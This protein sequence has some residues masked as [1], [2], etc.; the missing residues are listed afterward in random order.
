MTAAGPAE[1]VVEAAAAASAA[2]KRGL[3]ERR[4]FEV[5]HE[6]INILVLLLLSK[7]GEL[8]EDLSQ[9]YSL[10]DVLDDSGCMQLPTDE[11]F[12][13][14][15]GEMQRLLTVLYD[16]P[17]IKADRGRLA[18]LGRVL[19]KH[20]PPK[21]MS[22]ATC[23]SPSQLWR[24]QYSKAHAP[25]KRNTKP[26]PEEPENV[27]F[28]LMPDRAPSSVPR[29]E[30]SK[31]FKRWMLA[32]HP[33]K[34]GDEKQAARCSA[35]YSQA[36]AK[37][38]TVDGANPDS[39]VKV[40]ED[41]VYRQQ[42]QQAE[43]DWSRYKRAV[44]ERA[45]CSSATYLEQRL[46]KAARWHLG[47]RERQAGFLMD[48]ASAD[49]DGP[50]AVPR[51]NSN[52]QQGEGVQA[53]AARKPGSPGLAFGSRTDSH[54][55]P[56]SA[57]VRSSNTKG[58][59]SAPFSG[60]PSPNKASTREPLRPVQ[61]P[62]SDIVFMYSTADGEGL[63]SSFPNQVGRFTIRARDRLFRAVPCTPEPFHVVVRGRQTVATTVTPNP[64][65]SIGVEY[66]INVC[67]TYKIHVRGGKKGT[68]IFGSPYTLTVK[69]APVQPCQCAAEGV[70]LRKARAGEPSSFT[71]HRRDA[72]GKLIVKG[73]SRFV[74]AFSLADGEAGAD[75]Q[76]GAFA[77]AA[78]T[79]ELQDKGGTA[80][81]YFTQKV[82][83]K[84]DGT[85]VVQ[86]A[87]QRAG[88]YKLHV[89]LGVHSP[90][91]IHGSPFELHVAPA[92]IAAPS[93]E[94][95]DAMTTPLL[96]T[97]AAEA[98]V[99]RGA[100]GAI[101]V[102]AAK[103]TSNE[104]IV[105]GRP[106]FF[107]VLARDA[108]GNDV[109]LEALTTKA[110]GGEGGEGGGGGSGAGS[111]PSSPLKSPTKGGVG[112]R[113]GEGFR[114]TL[115]SS[116][117]RSLPA[118]CV[119][120]P[121]GQ[122]E[123][124]AIA[125][126][127]EAHTLNVTYGG[128][129][130]RRSPRQIAV[131]AGPLDL[132]HVTTTI[133]ACEAGRVSI[134]AVARDV[135]GNESG[136]KLLGAAIVP[137]A[138]TSIH[139]E[140]EDALGDR[141]EV[142][143]PHVPMLAKSASANERA[144]AEAEA[145]TR[146]PGS[147]AS[148][149]NMVRSVFSSDGGVEGVVVPAEWR[150]YLEKR[151]AKMA[152]ARGGPDGGYA[153]EGT[154]PSSVL[155]DDGAETASCSSSSC[156]SSSDASGEVS[157]PTS[158]KPTPH[159]KS[160]GPRA[161]Q[162]SALWFSGRGASMRSLVSK[163]GGWELPADVASE[164]RALLST[165]D[166]TKADSYTL[167][168]WAENH[169]GEGLANPER[170]GACV[171]DLATPL[172]KHA[173]VVLMQPLQL[174]PGAFSLRHSQ[175]RMP[176]Q[177]EPPRAGQN[178]G[179]G[180]LAF[181]KFGNPLRSGGTVKLSLKQLTGPPP[182][183]LP[184]QP[185]G[186]ATQHIDHNDGMHEVQ[187]T[188]Y[189]AGDHQL[190]LTATP[191]NGTDSGG[192]GGAS[193]A[194]GVA[195]AAAGT[196]NGRVL[197]LRVLP[198]DLEPSKCV[199]KPLGTD[200]SVTTPSTVPADRRRGGGVSDRKPAIQL[201]AGQWASALLQCSDSYGNPR[202]AIAA[203]ATGL[204]LEL[205]EGC[206][207]E[208]DSTMLPPSQLKSEQRLNAD[209][210]IWLR[211]APLSSGARVLSIKLKGV[212]VFGSPLRL[213]VTAGPLQLRA[214]ELM[215]DGSKLCHLNERSS[216]KLIAKDAYGNV[217][218]KG[219][220]RFFVTM[221]R[222]D[223]AGGGADGS[224]AVQHVPV[225]DDGS[226][227]Y[228]VEY[229]CTAVG[230]HSVS[231]HHGSLDGD[232]LPGSPFALRCLPGSPHLPACRFVSA[233]HGMRALM[234]ERDLASPQVFLG[235]VAACMGKLRV[236]VRLVD[237]GGLS[238]QMSS[239]R[240]VMLAMLP[241]RAPEPAAAGPSDADADGA[242]DGCDA[243]PRATK[244][245]ER[246][247]LAPT[248]KAHEAALAAWVTKTWKAQAAA[249]PAGGGGGA[250]SL[251]DGIR[252]VGGDDP[253]RLLDG[254]VLA[255]LERVPAAGG[256]PASVEEADG[257]GGST[258]IYEATVELK[259]MGHFRLAL[260]GSGGHTVTPAVAA[261]EVTP[262][263]AHALSCVVGGDAVERSCG[264]VGQPVDIWLQAHD[265]GGN[266]VVKGGDKV[267]VKVVTAPTNAPQVKAVVRDEGNGM[268]TLK[269]VPSTAGG[270]GLA[271]MVGRDHVGGSPFNF[272]IYRSPTSAANA[273]KHLG[274]PPLP[275]A[276]GLAD[277]GKGS[278]RGSA[279]DSPHSSR[280][281]A[282]PRGAPPAANTPRGNSP[283]RDSSRDGPVVQPSAL[284]PRAPSPRGGGSGSSSTG[285]GADS[286]ADSRTDSRASSPRLSRD[287]AR[288]ASPR[289]SRDAA[290]DAER[291][292]PT[293]AFAPSPAAPPPG[294][295]SK[296]PRGV[297]PLPMATGKA[298]T[299]GR[300]RDR[301][302][303]AHAPVSAR[304]APRGRSLSR[305]E[306]DWSALPE[307]LAAGLA[308]AGLAA[309]GGGPP[310]PS[311]VPP[312]RPSGHAL[313]DNPLPSPKDRDANSYVNKR[314]ESARA[315]PRR[316]T[317]P[318]AGSPRAPAPATFSHRGERHHSSPA[319]AASPRSS[320]AGRPPKGSGIA[321]APPA[322][323]PREA[324]KDSYAAA[325]S[326]SPNVPRS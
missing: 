137:H 6:E 112:D 165:Y 270:Y 287:A 280:R 163:A 97:V 214:C 151:E 131:V 290:R 316:S 33:D 253:R 158:P 198:A 313:F 273:L 95:T 265:S 90:V 147:L 55:T 144:E 184:I 179:L 233:H 139:T 177:K 161:Q 54:A 240:Q 167:L 264:Y 44:S 101:N 46:L 140:T 228:A 282:S 268:Y 187:L 209:G 291:D 109:R 223:G 172:D 169:S 43:P 199:L 149:R 256:A 64:D 73:T 325:P 121:C 319:R 124:R 89:T 57:P 269:M 182:S 285:G 148:M 98:K 78:A 200:G 259:R 229:T 130:V 22:F 311:C 202:P 267:S 114:A 69:A 192:G 218:P 220:E 227:S 170:A 320:G 16:A 242:A 305:E 248:P 59:F 249:V 94:L 110:W 142:L 136:A 297:P 212:H 138:A 298:F 155:I 195:A 62:A 106:F 85:F 250:S 17:S 263:R 258:C 141:F 243:E 257:E 276:G 53:S 235:Q 178:F 65:G 322:A 119:R 281:R 34:G 3:S 125:F 157:A 39:E 82:V 1:A 234:P 293:S 306:R 300:V 153:S 9:L 42:Q 18:E 211:Y 102:N 317:T 11:A 47:R 312:L 162:A 286:R 99:S 74:V 81:Q 279:R 129:A 175:V 216:F 8:D 289:P 217:Q 203:I 159:S 70:G 326:P 245:T 166:L 21:Q 225:K 221:R 219:G 91:E 111:N 246:D 260:C 127:A 28:I 56:P 63:T 197:K 226:G 261:L 247:L 143:R 68:H 133:H 277:S 308:A 206:G 15:E 36:M 304:D 123:I 107:R 19:L 29:N 274:V 88:T 232:V 194:G 135:Y 60:A 122:L 168:L 193:A 288:D 134:T 45:Y 296:A 7:C 309:A 40:D 191:L 171:D 30:L 41:L 188:Q 104:P 37:G 254:A 67:G 80:D 302:E 164:G 49:A 186:M 215:G 146:R 23:P 103:D 272:T 255:T 189:R 35:L 278:A 231:V 294:M 117:G 75:K 284:P 183:T 295:A 292:M 196:V 174:T 204:Q 115:T 299:P 118:S 241:E 12:A 32:N 190:V 266:A 154:L 237:K 92:A 145:A 239:P 105:A 224:G 275:T 132:R 128:V 66:S 301:D 244:P 26:P 61:G 120:L 52:E 315:A 314:A 210:S 238:T 262:G 2:V 307:R 108:L 152:A 207:G 25:P 20:A 96:P 87:T 321:G 79:K 4:I 77:G 318:R 113:S 236:Q 86:Y 230:L 173:R 126:A 181:D 283:R 323:T 208:E 14:R 205:S 84:N 100:D 213:D 83:D 185:P 50:G 93:C 31:T 51:V 76:R 48:I 222:L 201:R 5:K 176:Q 271:L 251:D 38:L 324:W 180:I 252:V 303:L 156:S 58:F 24:V 72:N 10:F 27:W 13:A 116:T 150:H 310:S 71:L 160:A